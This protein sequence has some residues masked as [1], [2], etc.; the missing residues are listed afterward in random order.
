MHVRGLPGCP[1]FA[2]RKRRWAVFVNGCFWHSHR[3]CYRAS[4][5][6]SNIAYWEPKLAGNAARDRV[7]IRRLKRLGYL[8]VVIWQCE[9]ARIAMLSTK[10]REIVKQNKRFGGT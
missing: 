5:P 8:V 10:V 7:N 1:D 9:T 3:H 6:K 2:N 4:K